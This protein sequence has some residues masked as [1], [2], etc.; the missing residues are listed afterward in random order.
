[1]AAHTKLTTIIGIL[2]FGTESTKASCPCCGLF[3]DLKVV[4][5]ETPG[6]FP[7]LQG[8]WYVVSDGHGRLD[9]EML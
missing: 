1:M 2:S 7:V 8:V 4:G 9:I 3:L 6:P 5:I